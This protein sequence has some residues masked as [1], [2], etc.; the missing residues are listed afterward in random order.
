MRNMHMLQVF[1]SLYMY[2]IFALNNL[3]RYADNLW[4]DR[5]VPLD[6]QTLGHYRLQRLIGRGGMGE[7]YLAEDTRLARQLAVKVI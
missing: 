4:K 1:F 6:G 7:V 3:F 2:D 5:A